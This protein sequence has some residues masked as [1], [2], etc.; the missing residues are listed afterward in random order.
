MDFKYMNFENSREAKCN[1]CDW[2]MKWGVLNT[3]SVFPIH[4]IQGLR[5]H[6]ELHEKKCMS[7]IAWLR[8]REIDVMK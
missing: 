2:S 5:R 8:L 7:L 6:A 1:S 4:V 3:Y